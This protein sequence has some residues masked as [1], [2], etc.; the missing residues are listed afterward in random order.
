MYAS[1]EDKKWP[2]FENICPLAPTVGPAGPNIARVSQ[3]PQ[4]S[5]VKK[6][7]SIDL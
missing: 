1:A 3:L 5:T 7:E 2:K 4:V 6:R